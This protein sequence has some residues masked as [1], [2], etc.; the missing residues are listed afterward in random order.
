M[1]GGRNQQTSASRL[2]EE[3]LG[4]GIR[5]GNLSMFREWWEDCGNPSSQYHICLGEGRADP[6]LS[7]LLTMN[8][9]MTTSA[10]IHSLGA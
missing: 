6:R 7:V 3:L 5:M 10:I 9:V 4:H 1:I 2:V 8:S